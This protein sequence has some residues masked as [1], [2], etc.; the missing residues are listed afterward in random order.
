M[1]KDCVR[2]QDDPDKREQCFLRHIKNYEDSHL[3][4]A[5]IPKKLSEEQ[6]D[7]ENTDSQEA[8][9]A[10]NEDDDLVQ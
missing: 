4:P 9:S 1:Q 3:N 7:E 5:K 2:Y 6:F 8:L 10:F